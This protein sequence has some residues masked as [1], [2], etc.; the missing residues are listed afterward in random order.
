MRTILIAI[1]MMTGLAAGPASA[2]DIDRTDPA[3]TAEAFILAFKARDL[4]ALAALVNEENREFFAA[5][6]EKGEA[7]RGYDDVFTGWRAEAADA[8]DGAMADARYEK[9]DEVFVP[10]GPMDGDEVTVIVL[11]KEDIGWAVEDVNSPDRARLME[12]PTTP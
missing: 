7:H 12:M 11:T 10:F 2:A 9:A 1:L 6:A 4:Q 5:L 8:W 3:A